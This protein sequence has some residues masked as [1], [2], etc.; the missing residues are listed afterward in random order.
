M[1]A[2][3]AGAPA[4]AGKVQTVAESFRAV[5]L[6]GMTILL[7]GITATLRYDSY[8]AKQ[9]QAKHDETHNFRHF[10]ADPV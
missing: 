1:V 9:L 6:Y 5:L 8:C 10:M 2:H 3:S 4:V 7:Y